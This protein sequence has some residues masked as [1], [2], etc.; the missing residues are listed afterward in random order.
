MKIERSGERAIV[1]WWQGLSVLSTCIRYL[2]DIIYNRKGV[3]RA[4]EDQTGYAPC[5]IPEPRAL[6]SPALSMD[7][8]YRSLQCAALFRR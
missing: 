1:K 2:V 4:S 3:L 6:I 5:A 7:I 8:E